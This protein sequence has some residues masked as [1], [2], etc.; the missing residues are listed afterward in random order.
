MPEFFLKKSPRKIKKIIT[1]E[2]INIFFF[3]ILSSVQQLAKKIKLL[4]YD[5]I[6]DPMKKTDKI[7][8]FI[9]LAVAFIGYLSFGLFH[10]TKFQTADERYWMY[11]DPSNG[12]IYSYWN[13]IANGKWEET[14]INDKP[15][16]SLAYVSG[17]ALLFKEKPAE[18]LFSQK[19]IERVYNPQEIERV[20][21]LF[22]LPLLIF[23]GLFCLLLF[24]LVGKFTKNYWIALWS[25]IFI[26][27]S[28][29]LL[30]ISQIVNPDSVLWSFSAGTI[31]SFFAYLKSKEKKFI[32][33]TALFL[34][35]SLL[36]KYSAIILVPFFLAAII[37][38]SFFERVD[39]KIKTSREV[40]V[41]LGNY[42]ATIFG[43]LAIFSVLLPMVFANPD[44]LYKQT[45]L[46]LNG[47]QYVVMII[48]A[49]ILLLFFDIIIF[50]SKIF[51]WFVEKLKFLKNF[52][53]KFLSFIF[54]VIFAI[55]IFIWMTDTEYGKAIIERVSF[56]AEKGTKFYLEKFPTRV[57]L[58]FVPLLFSLT[59]LA[60]FSLLF[61]LAK[62]AIKKVVYAKEIFLVLFFMVAFYSAVLFQNL[63]VTIRYSIMIYPLVFVLAS[64][65]LWEVFSWEKLRNINK[66]WITAAILIIS[67][68]NLWMT[69]PFYFNYANSLL[70]ENRIIT[71]A[72]GYGGYE[73][74]QFL[75]QLPNSDK[76][77]VWTDYNGYCPFFKGRCVMGKSDGKF[78]LKDG[79]AVPD[80]FVKTRRGSIMYR[81]MWDTVNSNYLCEKKDTAWELTING[82]A[83]NYVKIFKYKPEDNEQCV[84]KK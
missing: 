23:N 39:G 60:L 54:L 9:F 51:F 21:F 19:S 49:I 79:D 24:W 63:L 17:V 27:L 58:E 30:G 47:F 57:I 45:F 10:L 44:Y 16:V 46:Q 72:W 25:T 75:N 37:I 2:N 69:K 71:D 36:T 40:G 83:K 33:L 5:V 8:V 11:E 26:L 65:G 3:C 55:V 53:P 29:V 43:A 48:A 62:S 41:F 68:L 81:S 77:L 70:P 78:K 38:N 74:A 64:F 76:L 6:M 20:H 4:Y 22:R 66:I 42:V 35:F 67:F 18:N 80:Y 34:G 82:K 56:D 31:F 13:A 28:P 14:Y 32:F 1:T 52:A 73:A 15:G 59:P 84:Y 7:Y 12:R 50:K 61:I